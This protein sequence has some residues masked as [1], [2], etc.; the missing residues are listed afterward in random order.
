MEIVRT[1]MR[2]G[3]KRVRIALERLSLRVLPRAVPLMRS[4]SSPFYSVSSSLHK[5][6]YLLYHTHLVVS[7]LLLFR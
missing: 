7:G 2:A 6:Y 5:S 3:A 1:A 4:L